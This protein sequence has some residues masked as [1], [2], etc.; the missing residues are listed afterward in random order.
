MFNGA[1]KAYWDSL[2]DLKVTP[3]LIGLGIAW[4]LA[5]P[6]WAAWRPRSAP[7][8]FR[9]SRRCARPEMRAA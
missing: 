1:Q 8:G 9:L 3:G 2:F 6:C 7:R 4:A 5:S